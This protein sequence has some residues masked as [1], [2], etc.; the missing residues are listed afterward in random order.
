MPTSHTSQQEIR[1]ARRC[2]PVMHPARTLNAH[3]QNST[4]AQLGESASPIPSTQR[5]T[6]DEALHPSHPPQGPL[7]PPRPTGRSSQGETCTL[8]V[9]PQQKR[10]MIRPRGTLSPLCMQVFTNGG[11]K[12]GPFLALETHP[13]ILPLAR[14][15]APRPL[16]ELCVVR[17]QGGKRVS[18]GV[19]GEFLMWDERL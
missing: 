14:L 13:F 1:G 19:Q 7:I 2:S 17:G 12:E 6:G 5:T 15:F 9:E 3:P 18:C 16:S 8:K 11:R 10:A 4:P